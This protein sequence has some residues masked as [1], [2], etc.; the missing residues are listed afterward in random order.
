MNERSEALGS[1]AATPSRTGRRV[2]AALAG[3]ALVAAGAHVAVPIP[4][5]AVPATLQVF[6]V[7]VVG[8]LLG[9]RLGAASLVTYLVLGVMGLPVF[10]PFGAPGLARLV[11][12]TGGYLLAFPVAAALT[13]LLTRGATGRVG[14]LRI[15]AGCLLGLLAIHIGGL[16]QLSIL[17]GPAI[18]FQAGVLPFLVPDLLKVALAAAAIALLRRPVGRLV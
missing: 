14:M 15:A 5:S 12:P 4:G 9:P 8:G 18:A 11:G 17:V 7:L 1:L 13:G 3:T 16:A 2:I 6:A 10:A